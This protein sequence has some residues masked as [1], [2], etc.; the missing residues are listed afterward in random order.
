MTIVKSV[1]ISIIIFIIINYNVIKSFA[2]TKIT[3]R[4]YLPIHIYIYID[5]DLYSYINIYI[6]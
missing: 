1:L 5:N 6:T 3:T 2:Q 4:Y